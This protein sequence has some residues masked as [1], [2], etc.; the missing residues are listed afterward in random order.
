MA[1]SVCLCCCFVDEFK[2]YIV[3]TSVYI[4]I[5]IY[6]FRPTYSHRLNEQ[7]LCVN[8]NASNCFDSFLLRLLP[9]NKNERTDRRHSHTHIVIVPR[10]AIEL[11]PLWANRVPLV[12]VGAVWKKQPWTVGK[13]L[14]QWKKFSIK[15]PATSGSISLA[16]H[17]HS[18]GRDIHSHAHTHTHLLGV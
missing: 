7:C 4:F 8:A 1:A 3:H 13:K 11:S 15:D 14:S 5:Y 18:I 12:W 17:T 6:I 16:W 2:P 9:K 10:Q